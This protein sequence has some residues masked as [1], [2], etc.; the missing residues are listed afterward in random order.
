MKAPLQLAVCGASSA[1]GGLGAALGLA[2]EGGLTAAF[3]RNAAFGL[4]SAFGVSAAF[5]LTSTFGV[6]AAFGL[7]S[8]FGVSAAFEIATGFATEVQAAE[9]IAP[10]ASAPVSTVAA[11]GASAGELRDPTRPPRAPASAASAREA[12]PVLSAVLTFSGKRTAIF[13]G[14]L[15]RNGSVVG[16]YTIDSILADGIRYRHAGEVHE[17]HLA[18]SE[19]TVKKAAAVAPRAPIGVEQ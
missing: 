3:R 12:A 15:V 1:A 2:A 13:N 11:S 9:A 7:T 14:Q 6:S 19:S 5:G 16:P 10:A 17:L 4:T 8:A 18:H